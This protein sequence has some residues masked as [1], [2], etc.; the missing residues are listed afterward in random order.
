MASSFLVDPLQLWRDAVT[1]LEGEVNSLATGSSKNEQIVSALHQFSSVT[2][3]MEQ[4]LEKV[5]GGYLRRANLPSRKE[6]LELAESLR[7][8]EDKVDRL[9]PADAVIAAGPPRPPR[10]RQP[11]AAVPIER[12]A[13]AAETA[14]ATTRPTSPSS[15]STQA[16]ATTKDTAPSKLPVPA[17]A[18]ARTKTPPRTKAPTPA[19]P[20]KRPVSRRKGG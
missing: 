20:A 14:T 4:L 17:R 18:P 11:M 16:A 3:G 10:T 2:L 9:L 1:K 13:P 5:I 15:A 6:V 7:R 19:A 12:P 8:I